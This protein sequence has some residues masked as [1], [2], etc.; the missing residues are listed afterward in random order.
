MRPTRYEAKAVSFVMVMFQG[1]D[2]YGL[3]DDREPGDFY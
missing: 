2:R 3:L 1:L